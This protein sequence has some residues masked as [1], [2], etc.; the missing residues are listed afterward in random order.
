[1]LMTGATLQPA[2]KRPIEILRYLVKSLAQTNL[3]P[4]WAAAAQI[5]D[6]DRMRHPPARNP[7]WTATTYAIN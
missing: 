2:R 5:A 3:L 4:Q 1:M 7:I 6:N